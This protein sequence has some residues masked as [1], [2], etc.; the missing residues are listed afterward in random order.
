MKSL[1]ERLEQV[2]KDTNEVLDRNH[3][4]QSTIAQLENRKQDLDSE[5]EQKKQ[6]QKDFL[7]PEIERMKAL[8]AE[9]KQQLEEGAEAIEKQQTENKELEE[10]LGGL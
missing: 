5:Y 7:E 10:R 3:T 9:R 2:K 4:L 8:I 1:E 6:A